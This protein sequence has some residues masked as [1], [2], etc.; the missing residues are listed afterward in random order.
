MHITDTQLKRWNVQVWSRYRGQSQN[1]SNTC[2]HT[3]SAGEGLR[4]K[5]AL[6]LVDFSLSP[7]RRH[8]GANIMFTNED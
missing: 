1:G 8:M 7:S 4:P 5:Q 6:V 2:Y 3:D